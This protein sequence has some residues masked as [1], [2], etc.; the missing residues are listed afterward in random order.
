MSAPDTLFLSDSEEKNVPMDGL[1]FFIS[2][3]WDTIR[4]Q[5]E[6]N[7]PDQRAMVA[8]Y[9]CNE[10]KEEAIALI[11]AQLS[12]LEVSTAKSIVDDFK[13]QCL[14]I[15]DS[16]LGHYKEV[17]IQYDKPTFKKILAELREQI[18]SRM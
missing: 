11:T 2:S 13:E 5:K 18:Y 16:A 17:A 7:L 15:S 8:S 14:T 12:A 9:R 3:A 4:N 6:L 10:L 1:S